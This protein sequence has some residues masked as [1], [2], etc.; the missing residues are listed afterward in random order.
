M[1][2]VDSVLGLD[3]LLEGV[4]GLSADLHGLGAGSGASGEEHELLEREFVT[5]VRSSVDNV[6]R[7]ARKV[8]RRL[9]ACEVGKVLVERD[10]LA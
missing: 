8:E 3:D 9:D 6:E 5:G 1:R 4:V 7:G 2:T 10:T